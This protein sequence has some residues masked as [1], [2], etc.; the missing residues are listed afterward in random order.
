MLN[1][2]SAIKHAGFKPCMFNGAFFLFNILLPLAHEFVNL[3]NSVY[4]S[5]AMVFLL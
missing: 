1:K 4:V 3:N 5:Y 2:K